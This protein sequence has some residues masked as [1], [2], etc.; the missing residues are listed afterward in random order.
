LVYAFATLFCI[1][2]STVYE[3]Y[4][5]G[6][7]SNFMVYLFLFPLIGGVLPFTL[8]RLTRHGAFPPRIS[9]NL[10]NSG[11]ATLAV[12][13]AMQGALEIYGTTSNYMPVYWNVGIALIVMAT[14]LY[15]FSVSGRMVSR[16]R[17][18]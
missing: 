13:S 8:L 1:V 15:F 17:R 11:I 4:G 7:Y 16:K 2:F 10:Y 12:G 3:H 6:V 5:H 18:V 14:I 9:F